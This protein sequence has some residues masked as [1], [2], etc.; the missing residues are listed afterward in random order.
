MAKCTKCGANVN[1]NL[2]FLK[3]DAVCGLCRFRDNPPRMHLALLKDTTGRSLYNLTQKVYES[4]MGIEDF[5]ECGW[6]VREIKDR[7]KFTFYRMEF[8]GTV[9]CVRFPNA[10]YPFKYYRCPK[11]IQCRN[12]MA[13]ERV[14]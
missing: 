12:Q 14:T 11:F 5:E 4:E 9:K 8:Y 1:N 3:T 13:K 7:N 6:F 2:S 10:D